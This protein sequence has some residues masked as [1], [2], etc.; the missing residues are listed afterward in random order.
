MPP[1]ELAALKQSSAALI[2]QCSLR[3]K[4]AFRS[5][6]YDVE[7]TTHNKNK[8]KP[9]FKGGFSGLKEICIIF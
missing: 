9:P 1:A 3:R 2:R 4:I 6:T 5:G 8:E 7:T